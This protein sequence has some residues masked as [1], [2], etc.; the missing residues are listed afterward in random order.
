MKKRIMSVLLVLTM[1]L[2]LVPTAVFA[3]ADEGEQGTEEMRL[4]ADVA[5]GENGGSDGKITYLSIGESMTNGYGNE[6]YYPG[7]D[8]EEDGFVQGWQLPRMGDLDRD[9]YCDEGEPQLSNVFGKGQ[10]DVETY[11]SMFYADLEA[12]AQ[13]EGID[14]EWDTWAISGQ[15]P[16]DFFWLMQG[17]WDK[18]GTAATRYF[19]NGDYGYMSA[20]HDYEQQ[21][22]LLSVYNNGTADD[23]TDD[24][25][26]YNGDKYTSRVWKTGHNGEDYLGRFIAAEFGRYSHNLNAGINDPAWYGADYYNTNVEEGYKLYSYPG[27]DEYI[28]N[29]IRKEY[30]EAIAKADVISVNLG[31]H[32][33]S[34]IVS[35]RLQSLFTGT[36][37]KY[38][39]KR[40]TSSAILD[41]LK[42]S[43][44]PQDQAIA[45]LYRTVKDLIVEEIGGKAKD[46][47]T[48]DDY[49]TIIDV[50]C[51]ATLSFM[52]TYNKSLDIIRE[53]NPDAEIIIFG[54]SNFQE[55]MKFDLGNGEVMDMGAVFGKLCDLTNA[56]RAGWVADAR[57][58]IYVAPKENMDL[59][60]D[61]FARND[62]NVVYLARTIESLSKDW[63]FASPTINTIL[64]TGASDLKQEHAISELYTRETNAKFTKGEALTADELATVKRVIADLQTIAATKTFSCSAEAV[65]GEGGLN[66]GNAAEK[67]VTEGLAAMEGHEIASLHLWIRCFMGEGIGCHPSKLGHAQQYEIMK[68]AWNEGFTGEDYLESEM[69][70]V[71]TGEKIYA[72]L[73]EL[74]FINE[75]KAYAIVD[76]VV[77]LL[78]DGEL[79]DDDIK[80]I[81]V[82]IYKLLTGQVE[83]PVVT[84]VNNGVSGSSS[85]G[86]GTELTVEQKLDVINTVYGVLK[87]DGYLNEVAQVEEIKEIFD[88]VEAESPETALEVFETVFYGVMAPGE[89]TEEKQAEIID[90]VYKT[91][92][93]SDMDAS[94]KMNVVEKVTGLV[95]GSATG[96]PVD[97]QAVVGA[98]RTELK[99]SGHFTD[100]Q[101]VEI[102]NNVYAIIMAGNE[103]AKA[104]AADE[105]HNNLLGRKD[106]SAQDKAEI[107]AIVYTVLEEYGLVDYAIAGALG[108]A[109]LTAQSKGYIDAAIKGLQIAQG[110]IDTAKDYV[111][112]KVPAEYEDIR[113]LMIEELDNTKATLAELE[114][115]LQKDPT[116]VTVADLLAFEDDLDDHLTTLSKLGLAV[117]VEM[118]PYIKKIN[119]GIVEFNAVVEGIIDEAYAIISTV[120]SFPAAYAEWV[121]SIG[122]KVDAFSPELGALVRKYLNDNAADAMAILAVYGEEA[123]VMLVAEAVAT[124]GELADVAMELVYVLSVYGEDIYAAVENNA[125]VKALI[126]EVKAQL[127]KAEA[128]VKAIEE[129]PFTNAYEAYI[130]D[131]QAALDALYTE[132][133]VLNGKLQ[134]VVYS[135]IEDVDPIA[136]EALADA[137][138]ALCEAMGITYDA[139]EGYMGWLADHA[140]AMV[141]EILCAVLDNTVEFLVAASPVFDQAAY[142][143]LY[144]NPETVIAFFTENADKI[145]ELTEKYG[146]AVLGVIAYVG[147]TYGPEVLD[148]VINN[149]CEALDMFMEWYDAYGYRI[150]PM[151]DVYLEALGVYDAIDEQLATVK[152]M[153]SELDAHILAQIAAL[154]AA[155]KDAHDELRAEIEAEIEALYAQLMAFLK[156]NINAYYVVGPNS[157]YVALGDAG[158]YGPAADM[159]A[160][161]LGMS[162]KFANLTFADATAGEVLDTLNAGEI[163]K[164]DLITLGFSANTFTAAVVADLMNAVFGEEVEKDWAALVTEQGAE[165]IEAALAELQAYVTE[166]AGDEM[167]AA[168]L[169]VAVESFAYTYINHLVDYVVVS[170]AIHEINADALLVLVGMHNPMDGVV[171]ALNEE[172]ELDLGEYLDYLVMLTNIYSFGYALIGEDTIYVDAPDVETKYDGGVMAIEDFVSELLFF[173][174]TVVNYEPTDAGYKYIQEQIYNA[175]HPTLAEKEPCQH[176]APANLKFQWAGDYSTCVAVYTCSLCGE[177]FT[178]ECL[179]EILETKNPTEEEEGYVKYQAS[180]E[181]AGVTY[182]DTQVVTLAKL[183]APDTGDTTMIGAYVAVMLVAAAGA[184]VVLKKKKHA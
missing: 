125:E 18:I 180:V 34:S 105:L 175:L 36:V 20:I 152:A 140:Q 26:I 147:Y 81:A 80:A 123:V 118:D 143:W 144:N 48:E 62:T 44:D 119:K 63:D 182:T 92:M 165:V 141:C 120:E 4:P 173:E 64:G 58:C 130:A 50:Y 43:D 3:N 113:D 116:T 79:S 10:T 108:Y 51:Y 184:F 14:V 8:L 69:A 178:K 61:E 99:A 56:Y 77:E 41:V 57:D 33:F 2:S 90:D 39:D 139:A 13:K 157:Y 75:D 106:L 115:L 52:Y 111:N 86:S 161:E 42:A 102:I 129:K 164:A 73:E 31:T 85:S 103:A 172:T 25:T 150:W 19:A 114:A 53:L 146:A 101:I 66:V 159:L 110:A 136:A 149:P 24:I 38:D 132:I 148:F 117:G 7:Y 107:V 142:D 121:E 166:E 97:T 112:K 160:A 104:A 67:L 1:L 91:V 183:P 109:Y 70:I 12:A 89:L 32:S 84:P 55:G 65:F 40:S 82:Y 87:T 179:V 30:R 47:M 163:A 23:K 21:D 6:G 46:F 98:L 128:L 49:N 171:V 174:E 154:N 29:N 9:A 155:L 5:G 88:I 95:G 11:A 122:A 138:D 158:A 76:K 168:M 145:A 131:K 59:L 133:A 71:L 15:R 156:A 181:I 22:G 162:D 60:I 72:E 94:V 127:A 137:I 135:V 100:E 169:T 27:A 126:A 96:L 124:Y 83:V 37:D 45:K 68:A 28:L 93:E 16:E 151:I 78:K 54:M 167:I 153:L 74:G 35:S 134:T 176:G 170:E 177:A 17:A